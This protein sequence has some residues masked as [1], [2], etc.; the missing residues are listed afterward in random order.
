MVPLDGKLHSYLFREGYT[1]TRHKYSGRYLKAFLADGSPLS[2]SVVKLFRI[3]PL[4]WRTHSGAEV[5]L[6][7]QHKG[8]NWA[9]E[10]KF[11]DAPTRTKSMLSA[12]SDLQLEKLWVIYPGKES[13][14]LDKKIHVLSVYDIP[15]PWVY[16]E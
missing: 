2:W 9:I 8:K 16:S 5:D 7:W 3:G 4:F 1:A 10:F 15:V 12:L 6:F 11:S 14:H 13:Y